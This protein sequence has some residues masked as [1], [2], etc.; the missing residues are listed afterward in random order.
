M[1]V[2]YMTIDEVIRKRQTLRI[3]QAELALEVE[4][5]R[6]ALN[7]IEAQRINDETF[8]CRLSD[9]LDRIAAAR[10]EKAQEVTA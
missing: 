8:N 9:A 2:N 1:K 6:Q 4:I 10:I 5:N 3:T 7:A